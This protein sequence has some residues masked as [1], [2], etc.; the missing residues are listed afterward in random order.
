M[1]GCARTGLKGAREAEP[2]VRG[3]CPEF[4]DPEG[5]AGGEGSQLGDAEDQVNASAELL[6]GELEVAQFRHL[7]NLLSVRR[8]GDRLEGFNE[9]VRQVGEST[10]QIKRVQ[11]TCYTK[12]TAS[13]GSGNSGDRYWVVTTFQVQSC[14]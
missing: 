7:P 1:D 4:A 6:V 2:E 13:G 9:R 5:G 11:I 10:D 14:S 3:Q 8:A 12:L